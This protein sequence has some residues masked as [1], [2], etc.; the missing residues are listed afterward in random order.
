MMEINEY[1]FS[2]E[3]EQKPNKQGH[4]QPKVVLKICSNL[5]YHIVIFNM[6]L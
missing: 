6:K 2:K 3:A 5:I 4:T 1:T